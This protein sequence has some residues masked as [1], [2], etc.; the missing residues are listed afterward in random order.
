MLRV[1]QTDTMTCGPGDPSTAWS[2][3]QLEAAL[4]ALLDSGDAGVVEMV[5]T[6]LLQAVAHRASDI[7]LEPWDDATG[8]RFRIDGMLHDVAR[9]PREHHGRVVGRIKVLS[10]ILTYQKDLPQDGR[11]DPDATPCGKGMRVSTFPTVAGEKIVM[12]LL[13]CNPGLFRLGSLGFQPETETALR[14][15]IT[16]PHGTLL[17]TGPASSG[18]TTTIYA[19]LQELLHARRAVHVVTIEDPVEYRLGHVAQ[20]EINMHTG[21]TFEA[22]LRAALRQDPEVIMLGEIRDA[23]TARAAIQAG[24][25]GH[26]VISTIHSGSA[27]GVFC[28]LLDMGIEPFL[29][30]SSISGVLAQRLVRRI[31]PHCAVPY[32]PPTG[33]RARFGLTDP[34]LVLQHGAGCDVCQGIGYQGRNAL[35]EL[36][37]VTESLSELI[38]TRPRTHAVQE[39]ALRAGMT[40]LADSAACCVRQ[41]ITTVEE[42][43]RVLPRPGVESTHEKRVHSARDGSILLELIAALFVFSLG[44]LGTLASFHYGIDKLRHAREVNAVVQILQNEVERLHA[45]PF[46]TLKEQENAPFLGGAPPL[47]DLAKGQAKETIKPYP[48]GAGNAKEIEITVEWVG[49][50]GRAIRR[51]VST[52]IADKGGRTP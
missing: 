51:T 19:L 25:T 4:G 46:D 48:I 30:A 52:L 22:A 42:A 18:K 1:I 11:I 34:D 15:L 10:R 23:E 41:S 27:A 29:I 21:F 3:V 16:R 12:R 31:C 20:T 33:L 13:D 47:E 39:A 40:P 36:L 24:L 8:V 44:L 37:T 32:A 5:D 14:E 45:L 35:G 38:L 50:N 28:R 49:D 17:L 7:H 2:W 43:D 9:F 6:L 26:L